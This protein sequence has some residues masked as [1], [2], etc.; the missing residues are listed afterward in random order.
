MS[1]RALLFSSDE[2][3]SSQLSQALSE[4]ELEIVHCREIFAAVEQVT[5]RS[6][7]LIVCDWDAGVEA[8]FLLKTSRELKASCEAVTVAVIDDRTRADAAK[9]IGADIVLLKPISAE[10][11][12]Y[13]LLSSDAFL[14]GL[15]GWL[16]EL[17]ARN[18]GAGKPDPAAH[19]MHAATLRNASAGMEPDLPSFCR[20]EKAHRRPTSHSLLIPFA[21]V[22]FVCAVAYPGSEPLRG[23][24]ANASTAANWIGTAVSKLEGAN[25]ETISVAQDFAR[26]SRS[27]AAR[28]IT[29]TPVLATAKPARIT[30]VPEPAVS[31]QQVVASVPLQIPES[32]QAPMAP[33]LSGTAVHT[34]PAILTSIEPVLVPAEV[35]KNLL[36]QVVQPS[37]PEQA[38]KAGI[39]G[40]VTFLASIGKDGRVEE[41]RL[42]GGYLVLADAAYRAVKQWRYK[43]Y[44]ADGRAVPAQTYVTIDFKRQ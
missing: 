11:A 39:E 36:Q 44:M 19:S 31:K 23:G 5:T 3:T 18:T 16:P 4:L 29:V 26:P 2:E 38:L 8:S 40:P 41:L 32:L 27:H 13:A 34:S 20:V 12:K 14:G 9:Q 42:V 22:L 35:A 17:M 30:P 25:V 1:P 15:R 43:P 28:H 33:G 24:V 21:V 37:Y 7:G 6:F 10:R